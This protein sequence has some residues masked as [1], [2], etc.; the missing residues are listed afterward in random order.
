MAFPYKRKI[1]GEAAAVLLQPLRSQAPAPAATAQ[2]LEAKPSPLP[3][4]YGPL[5]LGGRADRYYRPLVAPKWCRYGHWSPDGE[6]LTVTRI[7][8]AK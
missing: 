5:T 2:P 8:E 6:E 4:R 7:M 3:R 1:N